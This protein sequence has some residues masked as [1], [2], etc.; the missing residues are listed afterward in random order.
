[1]KHQPAL[2]GLRGVA[3][4]GVVAFHAG[5]SWAGGGFLGVSLFFTL[6]GF[7]ITTL[8]L[9]E[10]EETGA[11]DLP[12]FWAR[13]ARRLLPAAIATLLGV[14]ALAPVLATADQLVDLRAD[15][16]SALLYVANWRFVIEDRSYG[17]LFAVPSPV[18]HFWSLAIEEQLYVLFPLLVVA[19][20]RRLAPVLVAL[21][22]VSI[23]LGVVLPD[24]TAYYATPVRMGELLVGALLALVL[25]T[26]TVQIRAAGV[27]RTIGVVGAVALVA[28]LTSW[29]VVEQGSGWLYRGGF[30]LHAVASAVVIAAC[31]VDGPVRRALSLPPLQALG[32][33]SYGVYLIHW[34]VFV[35]MDDPLPV[36]LA[37]TLAL[38]TVSYV[39]LE[40]PIRTRRWRVPLVAVPA[41]IVLTSAVAVAST[42]DPP[43][44]IFRG[45]STVAPVLSPESYVPPSP[46]APRVAVFGDSTAL[47]TAFAL[48]GWGW[49]NGRI[50]MVNG[51]ARVGCSL[52]RGGE[53]DWVV[54]R[55]EVEPTCEWGER[56]RSIVSAGDLDIALIQ[57]GPW[58]V[59]DRRLEGAE[60]W[61]HIGEPAY[62]E[63]LER[64]MHAAVDVLSTGGTMVVWL[65]SPRIEFGRGQPNLPRDH[66]IS[67]PERMDRL[68]E[69]IRRVDAER[70]ELVVLDLAG[71]LR[72]LPGGEMDPHLRPD[73]VHFSEE[74]S[75]EI[76]D[77]LGPALIELAGA[78]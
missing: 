50:D 15:V 33:I 60:D 17:D 32:R 21:V 76:A 68:N 62:D 10:R 41:A 57:V 45:D 25:G 2:D 34:P 6:S 78:R 43:A 35:W 29:S 22:V 75:K 59:T 28:V 69:L 71:Y 55:F 74:A 23:V 4:A 7:L 42:L 19:V 72:S 54:A 77:W 3:V 13:R 73:G 31:L 51:D 36:E 66:P 61:T 64:E 14:A 47:R 1:M 52:G 49:L 39:A 8:L 26:G 18:L 46:T 38:A 27:P 58:D 12:A 5:W 11:I 65:T 44:P 37:V 56:W 24:T 53:V 20:R 48:K 9:R 16:V 30:V 63:F 67:D 70:E 40:Q